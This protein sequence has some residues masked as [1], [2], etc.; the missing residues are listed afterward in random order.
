MALGTNA[1]NCCVSIS[2]GKAHTGCFPKSAVLLQWALHPRMADG[3]AQLMSDC[4]DYE[5]P[6]RCPASVFVD[7]MSFQGAGV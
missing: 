1:F 2:N 6:P 5:I 3:L 7:R 4:P